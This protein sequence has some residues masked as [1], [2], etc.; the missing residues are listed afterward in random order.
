MTRRDQFL[1]AAYGGE[2]WQPRQLSHA[3][4]LGSIWALCGME[5]EWHTLKK[6]LLYQ[7]GSELH[8]SLENPDAVQMLEA[9]DLERAKEEHAA[10]QQ[11]YRDSGVEVVMVDPDMPARPNQMFC[12]DLFAMTPEGAI[13]A[14]PA[15]IVRAGEE[16][17]VAR[18]LA[19]HG[20][21]ILKTLT[22]NA[23]FEGADLIWL[24]RQTA[25]LGQGLRTNAEAARQISRILE[26][27]GTRLITVD[28]PVGT[29]H[30]MGMLRIV[31][32]DLANSGPSGRNET[33]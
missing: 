22:A 29:M 14:R 2:G 16:R 33:V 18:A 26:E 15:S 4:E 7:P 27:I 23:K 6:V 24:N 5:T 28:M 3:C 21:P 9:I 30:L 11:A 20:I 1:T 31:D 8:A 13:L 19:E 10:L 32:E 17:Q 25:L 12:A